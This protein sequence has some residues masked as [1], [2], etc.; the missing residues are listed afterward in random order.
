MNN[1]NLDRDMFLLLIHEILTPRVIDKSYRCTHITNNM[2]ST[3][4]KAHLDRSS[5]TICSPTKTIDKNFQFGT[6][7]TYSSAMIIVSSIEVSSTYNACI[8]FFS[9]DDADIINKFQIAHLRYLRR[10]FM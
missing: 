5:R 3:L 10:I 7:S 4:L 1:M 2:F 8:V 6:M 9:D